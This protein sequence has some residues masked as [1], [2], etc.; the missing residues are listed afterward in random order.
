LVEID[1]KGKSID[2]KLDAYHLLISVL[3]HQRE[4]EDMSIGELCSSHDHLLKN[5]LKLNLQE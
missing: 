5:H 2:E 1:E 3:H 4:K